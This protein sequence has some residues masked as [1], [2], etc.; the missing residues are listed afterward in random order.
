NGCDIKGYTIANNFLSVT[1][2]SLTGNISSLI[3][4]KNGHEYVD[5][6]SRY[7]L[8]S[9]LYVMGADSTKTPSYPS[10]VIVEVKED[11]PLVSSLL[12]K[13]DA[14]GCKWLKRRIRVVYN[15]PWIDITN[16]FD[17]IGD[18]IKQ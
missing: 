11:G 2:D 7:D 5:T 1:I 18:L 15:Q 10:H 9:Y 4:R 17:K 6:T 8:N 16:S 12:V 14:P 13:S 3:K